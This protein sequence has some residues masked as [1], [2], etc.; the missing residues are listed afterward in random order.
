MQK[1]KDYS[2]GSDHADPVGDMRRAEAQKIARNI[3]NKIH[4]YGDVA[5]VLVLLFCFLW[6]RSY[7]LYV[8]LSILVAGVI[9]VGVLM[10][11]YGYKSRK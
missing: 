3:K 4:T 9:G 7:K 1:Q 6:L 2:V 8:A 10:S 5:I 11:W